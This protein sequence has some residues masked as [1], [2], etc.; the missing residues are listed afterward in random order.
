MPRMVGKRVQFDSDTWE[1]VVMHD[2]QDHRQPVGLMASLKDSVGARRKPRWTRMP[3]SHD[4]VQRLRS[5]S[6][7][8]GKNIGHALVMSGTI[9][10]S[11][12]AV[13][14]SFMSSKA[15]QSWQPL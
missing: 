2:T 1:A 5:D 4:A 14:S 9:R 10:S 6:D 3:F 8:H 7:V 12:G 11:P 15:S 13:S